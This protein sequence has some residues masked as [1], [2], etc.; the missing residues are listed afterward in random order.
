MRILW[1]IAI[2]YLLSS[3][4]S[5]AAEVKQ[6]EREAP[7]FIEYQS[8]KHLYSFLT[9]DYLPIL[10][11][12]GDPGNDKAEND[13]IYYLLKLSD[14]QFPAL[15]MEKRYSIERFRLEPV[16]LSA[17][18]GIAYRSGK[19]EESL[20]IGEM[21][22]DSEALFYKKG[23][24]LINLKWLKDAE[25]TL[26]Q[27]Q[28]HESLYIYAKIAL[29]QIEVRKGNLNEAENHLRQVISPSMPKSTLTDRLFLMLGQILYEKRTYKE[30]IDEFARVEA[31]SPLYRDSLNGQAWCL[32][33]LGEFER[34]VPFLREIIKVSFPDQ[35]EQEA[36]MALGYCYIKSGNAIKAAQ[37]YQEILE[38]F[39][40]N[41]GRL[42]RIIEN[43]ALRK[44]YLSILLNE[45][46]EPI[47]EE[48]AYYLSYLQKDS[49]INDLLRAF[50]HLRGLRYGFEEMGKGIIDDETYLENVKVGL[51]N[52]IDNI[53]IE[54]NKLKELLRNTKIPLTKGSEKALSEGN[55]YANQ[56]G[57]YI[58]KEWQQTISERQ[59][60]DETRLLIKLI[61]QD[62]L[63]DEFSRCYGNPIV[64]YIASTV[65][66]EKGKFTPHQIRSIASILDSIARDIASTKAK[67]KIIFEDML[68]GARKKIDNMVTA[69]LEKI[70]RLEAL[71]GEAQKNISSIKKNQEA[72]IN[73]IESHMLLNFI[74]A[75]YELGSL[76][77]RISEDLKRIKMPQDNEEHKKQVTSR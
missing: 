68:D 27:I 48:E 63:R 38:S 55:D 62:W 10:E 19:Y 33:N 14:L 26:G 25:T 57:N 69:D 47:N 46:T 11:R 53:E 4:L 74:R 15:D 64:C 16:S 44:R 54:I 41:E 29:A 72:N 9:S 77:A 73:I 20:N 58:F 12:A 34:A 22:D 28:S 51:D 61:L 65:N 32:I 23:M 36:M 37:H 70:R 5:V 40:V 24:T 67:K 52:I 75:R 50:D 31:G 2:V 3:Q 35:V 71:R 21:G 66:P 18:Q 6:V 56:Y 17:L 59:F 49:T 45:N 8:Q 1:T 43:R 42:S 7:S 60:T 30:A 39:T 13:L 76:K